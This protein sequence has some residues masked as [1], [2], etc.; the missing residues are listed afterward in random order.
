MRVRDGRIVGTLKLTFASG[1]TV[2]DVR[3]RLG[4][5]LRPLS[6]QNENEISRD[7]WDVA[8]P[9]RAPEVCTRTVYRKTALPPAELQ[10]LG[11]PSPPNKLG[12]SKDSIAD[13]EFSFIKPPMSTLASERSLGQSMSLSAWKR[14]QDRLEVM[15]RSLEAASAP[16]D[17]SRMK[18]HDWLAADVPSPH[19]DWLVELP[20]NKEESRKHRRSWLGAKSKILRA[21]RIGVRE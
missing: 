7:S 20:A 9:M 16:E 19:G 8:S 17:Q 5:H 4:R 3:R 21:L 2:A 6:D 18:V 11:T 1:E 13:A 10:P 14:Q 12:E 15:R